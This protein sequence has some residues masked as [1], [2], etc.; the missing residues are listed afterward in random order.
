MIIHPRKPVKTE[1]STVGDV[2]PRKAT[3]FKIRQH[4]DLETI[5]ENP[6]SHDLFTLV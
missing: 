1:A 6:N 5:G 4:Q 2:L 3:D